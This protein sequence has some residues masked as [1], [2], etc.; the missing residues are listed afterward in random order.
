MN[1]RALIFSLF[2]F[3][4][5]SGSGFHN[6]EHKDLTIDVL[7]RKFEKV[8]KILKHANKCG[9]IVRVAEPGPNP[10]HEVQMST[11]WQQDQPKVE[12]VY[13][14]ELRRAPIPNMENKPWKVKF[15]V[16]PKVLKYWDT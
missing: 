14:V 4:E 10:V 9:F 5:E 16:Y 3:S 8:T 2:S 7:K 13:C 15:L 12:Q 11:Y 6:I 1:N